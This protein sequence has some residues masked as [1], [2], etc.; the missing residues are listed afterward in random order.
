MQIGQHCQHRFAGLLFQPVQA[1]F[2]QP[3]VAAEAVDDEADDARPLALATGS[4]SVPTMCANTPPRSMSATSIDRA[5]DRFGESHVGDVALAQIDLGRAAG[6]F[7]DHRRRTA[8]AAARSDSSTASHRDGLVLVV[9]A[10]VHLGAHLAVDDHLRA[11]VARWASAAPGSCRC[12]ARCRRPCACS[13]WA[14]PISPPSAV[15]ALFSA[16]FCGLNG[17]TRTPRAPQQAAQ[18]R[19]PG[20]LAGIRRGALDHQG[21]A[22]HGYGVMRD[23]MDGH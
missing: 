1:R 10:R 19:R 23:R 16:M 18:R 17:A 22:R 9:V 20:A 5:V 4:A 2:E 3:D 8:R 12:A 11:G 14:R 21:A 13:A 6:A 15:T 7:D